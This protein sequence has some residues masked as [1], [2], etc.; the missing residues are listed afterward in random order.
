MDRHG[1]IVS[2][3]ISEI[4]EGRELYNNINRV[5]A[6]YKKMMDEKQTLAQ[7]PMSRTQKHAYEMAVL[8]FKLSCTR[9]GISVV[10]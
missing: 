3:V 9:A 7:T 2:V 4:L 5:K 6:H 8:D 10:E 1:E